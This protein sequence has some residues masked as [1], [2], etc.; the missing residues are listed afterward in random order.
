VQMAHLRTS[1][2]HNTQPGHSGVGFLVRLT[3]SKRHKQ[4]KDVRSCPASL[5]STSDSS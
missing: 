3:E 5:F 4:G 1:A 2:L